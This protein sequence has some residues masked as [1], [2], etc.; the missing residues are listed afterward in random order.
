MSSGS[1]ASLKSSPKPRIAVAEIRP[2][3]ADVAGTVFF[4][5]LIIG[6]TTAAA[7]FI[8]QRINV[9]VLP[10]VVVAV[11]ICAW[12]WGTWGGIWG[13]VLAWFGYL[14]FFIPPILTFYIRDAESAGRMAELVLTSLITLCLTLGLERSRQRFQSEHHHLREI[15]RQL[16]SGVLIAEAGSGQVV[17]ANDQVGR[18][19]DRPIPCPMTVRDYTGWEGFHLSDG[20]PYEPSERPLVRALTRGEAV[21]GEEYEILRR[22]G[23]RATLQVNAGPIRNEAGAVVEGVVT[24]HDVTARRR[25]EEEVLDLNARL[26]VRVQERTAELEATLKEL[27]SFAYSVAHDCRAPLRG[28]S[29]LCN[30]LA[31]EYSGRALDDQAQAYLD[32]MDDCVRKMDTLISDLLSYSRVARSRVQIQPVE[33]DPLVLG[34]VDQLRDFLRERQASVNVR[35]NLPAVLGNYEMLAKA[36]S[37]LLTNA[38]KFVAPGVQPKVDIWAEAKGDRIH[39][40]MEDNGIGIAPGYHDRIF[41]IF[42]RLNPADTYPGTGIGLS[43]ARAAVERIGG[44]IGVESNL[45]Q[46]SRFCIDLPRVP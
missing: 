34:V 35:G 37:N 27:D 8:H 6:L 32:R 1:V 42:Q 13:M 17:L 10:L 4:P 7:H 30:I 39:L 9:T 14:F 11:M 16:P 45:G 38:V 46:G 31:G 21:M 43:I 19:W 41:G 2:S 29:G 12:K 36:I 28:V 23:S 44:R 20:R 25:A 15:L 26:E 18:M 3:R 5:F 40:W 24:F 33:T 22:D